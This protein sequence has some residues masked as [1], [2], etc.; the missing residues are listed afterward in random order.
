MKI[1]KKIS[2]IK[3]LSMSYQRKDVIKKI[4]DLAYHLNT[5]LL[6]LYL[7]DDSNQNFNHWLNGEVAPTIIKIG[8]LKTK[9]NN[10]P[11]KSN[12]LKNILFIDFITD[13]ETLKQLEEV[14]LD[15]E[16]ELSSKK[17]SAEVLWKRFNDFYEDLTKRIG[18]EAKSLIKKS[19]IKSLV[20]KYLK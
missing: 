12:V 11:L 3:V 16:K 5:H 19:E 17:E 8:L 7:S 1:L 20:L 18:S 15:E 4:E 10:K 14:V 13:K 9:E 2:E 6:K